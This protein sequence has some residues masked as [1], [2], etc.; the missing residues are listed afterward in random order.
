MIEFTDMRPDVAVPA[1]EYQRLLGYPSGRTLDGRAAELAGQARDWYKGHGR[2][3]ICAR[4]ADTVDVEAASIRLD[5][6]PF[7]A[8]RL[9]TMLRRAEADEVAVGGVRAD[10]PRRSPSES[11]RNCP[12]R[13]LSFRTM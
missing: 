1:A 7:T 11:G 2:P 12:V 5:G 3:W 13:R 9:R 4:Q 6:V 8:S 10:A